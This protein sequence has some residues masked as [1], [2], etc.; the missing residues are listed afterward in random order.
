MGV[1]ALITKG[2]HGSVELLLR[3]D[4]RRLFSIIVLFSCYWRLLQC[5]KNCWKV[6]KH[7]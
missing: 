7:P 1:A 6:C 2:N 4:V 3:L 5:N